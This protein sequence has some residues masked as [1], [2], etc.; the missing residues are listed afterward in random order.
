MW[1]FHGGLS[2]SPAVKWP[3]GSSVFSR[4]GC[5]LINGVPSKTIPTFNSPK[6]R[7]EVGG[8]QGASSSFSEECYLPVTVMIYPAEAKKKRL[9]LLQQI[10]GQQPAQNKHIYLGFTHNFWCETVEAQMETGRFV[11]YKGIGRMAQEVLTVCA[12]LNAMESLMTRMTMTEQNIPVCTSQN[13][14]ENSNIWNVTF[15]TLKIIGGT[16]KQHKE[17][18]YRRGATFHYHPYF[19]REVWKI[20][21]LRN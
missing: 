3:Q 2:K 8:V 4:P 7:G 15:L 12:H 14:H 11:S 16:L 1:P 5:D 10:S 19:Q 9:Q 6:K 21:V 18:V 20:W 13:L 17:Q